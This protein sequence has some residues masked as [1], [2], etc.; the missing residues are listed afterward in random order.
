MNLNGKPT[1]PGELRTAITLYQ[2]AVS[3]ETGGFRKAIRGTKIAD[4]LC[5]WV[6]GHG[7]EA[8]KAAML[9]AA[10][11]ATVWLRYRSGVDA[12]CLVEKGGVLYEIV[13]EPDNVQERGEYMELTVLRMAGG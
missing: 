4:V 1:N 6:N 5:K 3:E 12:T 8:L 7:A 11:P 10:A 9:Q 13:G 2:R